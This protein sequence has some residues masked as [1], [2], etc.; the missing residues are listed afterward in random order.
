[1]QL[2]VLQLIAYSITV[3]VE[4]RSQSFFRENEDKRNDHQGGS[5][6]DKRNGGDRDQE[7]ACDAE[8]KP[9]LCESDDQG[10]GKLVRLAPGILVA[11]GPRGAIAIIAIQFFRRV[12]GNQTA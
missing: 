6:R 3:A 8:K 5:C 10:G 9:G 7:T 1:M 11:H 4:H 2:V 12:P